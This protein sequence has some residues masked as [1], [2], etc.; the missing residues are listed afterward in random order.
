MGSQTHSGLGFGA[1][2]AGFSACKWARQLYVAR[3]LAPGLVLG[4]LELALRT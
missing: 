2:G 4:L 1:F 3:K